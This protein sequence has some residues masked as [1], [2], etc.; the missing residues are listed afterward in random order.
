MMRRRACLLLAGIGAVAT[1]AGCSGGSDGLPPVGPSGP[2]TTVPPAIIGWEVVP[3][4]LVR[5]GLDPV[6]LRV[7]VTGD[8]SE[9]SFGIR[10]FASRA[11]VLT[12]TIESLTLGS[13]TAF[14]WEAT[15]TATDLLAG[16][17]AV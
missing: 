11:L 7:F 9:V 1:M 13:K 16:F 4:V 2:Q 17:E 8:A 15:T 10:G 5:G 3:S 12:R 14:V 6:R